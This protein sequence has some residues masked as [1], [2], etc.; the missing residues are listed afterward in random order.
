MI[1]S[2]CAIFRQAHGPVD[3]VQAERYQCIKRTEDQRG[4][5]QLPGKYCLHALPPDSQRRWKPLGRRS[6]T[7]PHV[8]VS[9]TVPL[10]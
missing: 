7:A 1:R 2:P 10:R 8:I 5:K 6:D 4:E 9:P 3:Q